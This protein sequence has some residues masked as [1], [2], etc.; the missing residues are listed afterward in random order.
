MLVSLICLCKTA[1]HFRTIF[2]DIALK[3]DKILSKRPKIARVLKFLQI[4]I[5]KLSDC[6]KNLVGGRLVLSFL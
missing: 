4:T 5:E 1:G 3:F 2:P 6:N